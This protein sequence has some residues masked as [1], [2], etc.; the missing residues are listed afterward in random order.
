[1]SK[2]FIG[3][4]QLGSEF[5]VGQIDSSTPDDLYLTSAGFEERT[6]TATESLDSEYEADWGIV[7]VNKEY[8]KR[9]NSEVT[10]THLK[11]QKESLEKNCKN[12]DVLMGS[13]LEAD[14]QLYTLRDGFQNFAGRDNLNITVD[15]TSFNRESL[16]VAFNIL[17]SLSNNITTRVLYVSPEE[18]GE[19][20]TKGHRLVRNV[21]G[22]A[23]IQNSSKPT[24]LI[25]LS[26]FE[27]DRAVSTIEEI[28]PGKVL[29]GIGNPPTKET[30]LEENLQKQEL[31]LSQQAT[32]RFRF[33]AD[34]ISDSKKDIKEVIQEYTDDYNLVLSPMS[35]KLSTLG[36][37]GAAR[38]SREVQVVYTIPSEYNLKNYSS[39]SEA[40]Y[41]DWVK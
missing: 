32:D 9:S 38:E 10:K 29:M 5:T 15:V 8:F 1:M 31:V 24:L 26:G 30:F 17:Y 34:S 21:I 33:S 41:I 2:Q 22:F 6:L 19:W 27:K 7:Y 18:H 36:A 35:T 25:I 20:L 11:K 23:G 13:W 28:E 3:S 4:E 16:L 37:W 40:M 39:G 12:V 14:E